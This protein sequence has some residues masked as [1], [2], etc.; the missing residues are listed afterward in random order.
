MVPIGGVGFLRCAQDFGARLRRRANAS[1]YPGEPANT[2]PELK[3]SG[4][5]FKLI[6]AGMV[7]ATNLLYLRDL[8]IR[9]VPGGLN[10]MVFCPV[11][12]I[13]SL[14]KSNRLPRPGLAFTLKL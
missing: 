13:Q 10:S 12:C 4:F 3:G 7:A 2:E 6:V 11:R 9:Y 5:F 1:I 14:F 8:R